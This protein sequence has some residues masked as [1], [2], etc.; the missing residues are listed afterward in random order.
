MGTTSSSLSNVT[1]P[2]YFTGVSTYSSDFQQIIQRAVEIAQ[3]PVTALQNQVTDNTSQI[4]ALQGLEPEVAAVGSDVAALATLATNQALSASSSDPGTVS[5]VNTGATAPGSYTV[6]DIT[7]LASAASETSLG[8]YTATQAV[9]TSGTVNLMVGSENY[10]LDLTGANENNIN[11]LASAINN[12]NAGVNATVLTSGSENYLVVSANDT[13]ATTLQL[14]DVLAP[15]DLVSN[16]GTGTETSLQTY[17][18]DT[19][20][21]VSAD[22]QFTLTVGSDNYNLDIAGNNNLDGLAQAINNA[23]AGVTA[24]VT[25]SAGSYS[26]SIASSGATT[27]QLNASPATELLSDTNQGSNASF[28]LNG[29]PITQSSNNVTSVIPGISFTLENTTSGSVTLS[30]ASDGSQLSDALQTL[31]T[32]YNT[33]VTQVSA[34]EGTSAGPLGG[35]LVINQISQDMQQLVTYYNPNGSSGIRSLSDLGV[36]FADNTGQLSF[37]PSTISGLSDTQLTDAFSF[38]GSASTGFGALASNFT[39]LTDP[40]SGVFEMEENGLT[41]QNT[42]LNDQI[43][44]LNAQVAQI[45]TDATAQAQ[46]AD[47]YVAE[48]QSQQTVL[49][50][51]IE[52]LNYVLYGK[53]TSSL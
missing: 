19:S 15:T 34:Q 12:A 43:T 35:D 5:V 36:T 6:S 8:S 25:G 14:S 48:L 38:L 13:G 51:S 3:L 18:D 11:G 42:T 33:L 50:A 21:P 10:T 53:P 47:A 22:G 16:T 26:L 2:Q 44:T 52:S 41:Q 4:T 29:I 1:A 37:D 30:L 17:A 46:Q 39:Q 28:E 20:T 9:S 27:I 7:S 45:Q 32:D 40:I 24:T 49:D 31:V 23:G